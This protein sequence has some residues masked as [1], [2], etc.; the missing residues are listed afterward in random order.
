MNIWSEGNIFQLDKKKDKK[1]V[2]N[3]HDIPLVPHA[4]KGLLKVVNRRFEECCKKRDCSQKNRGFPFI[5][6]DHGHDICY[7]PTA[8]NK[9]AD[10]VPPFL[11][12]IGTCKAH[13]SGD[14]NLLWKVLSHLGGPPQMI[15]VIHKFH[16]VKKCVRLKDGSKPFDV[17]QGLK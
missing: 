4:G 7:S 16:E 9:L 14:R 2:L 6:I 8:G 11:C 10:E 3:Y 17:E 13:G 15:I 12:F 5:P 1:N